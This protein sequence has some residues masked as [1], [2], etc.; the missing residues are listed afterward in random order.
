MGDLLRVQAKACTIQPLR[1]RRTHTARWNV[2][3]SK[4]AMS[5]MKNR[6][7]NAIA[8]KATNL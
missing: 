1:M 5:G 4:T 6:N 2:G 7:A 3:A 8:H